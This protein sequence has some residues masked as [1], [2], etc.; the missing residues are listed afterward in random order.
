[1]RRICR[2][3]PLQLAV[4]IVLSLFWLGFLSPRKAGAL[5]GPADLDTLDT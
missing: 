1:M 5:R 2:C 3:Q 4:A